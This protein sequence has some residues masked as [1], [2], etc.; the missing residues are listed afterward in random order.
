[1]NNKQYIK[2]NITLFKLTMYNFMQIDN[3]QIFSEE[4]HHLHVVFNKQ[5]RILQAHSQGAGGV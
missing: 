1:M 4:A 5:E 2:Q 3:V